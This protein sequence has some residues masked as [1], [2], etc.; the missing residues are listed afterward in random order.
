MFVNYAHHNQGVVSRKSLDP[1][2]SRKF[3]KKSLKKGAQTSLMCICDP[4]LTSG[5]Y[6]ADLKEAPVKIR[7]NR[8]KLD[9][10]QSQLWKLT[11]DFLKGAD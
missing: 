4:N 11:E 7:G 10:I 5:K 3:E 9:E 2:F 8:M 6:Y 1:S